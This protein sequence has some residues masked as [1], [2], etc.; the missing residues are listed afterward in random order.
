LRYIDMGIP[1]VVAANPP[2]ANRDGL[3]HRRTGGGD[4]C[5]KGF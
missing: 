4:Q 3:G 2:E 5:L 1:L